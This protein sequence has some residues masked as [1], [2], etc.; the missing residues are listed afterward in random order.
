MGQTA[1]TAGVDEQY[2]DDQQN[3]TP[4]Q[5]QQLQQQQQQSDVEEED[6]NTP[7]G[8]FVQVLYGSKTKNGMSLAYKLAQRYAIKHSPL[9]VNVCSID[10]FEPENM[11]KLEY[12]IFIMSTHENGTAAPNAKL[13][14]DWLQDVSQDFRYGK[15]WLTKLKF[16]V[17]GLGS[18]DYKRNY[19]VIA[20]D[21]KVQMKSLGAKLFARPCILDYS[22]SVDTNTRSNF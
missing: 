1:S 18:S 3:L 6:D 14:M 2:G 13:F 10:Q 5:K 8:P 20:K 22:D 21:V 9:P 19:N 15:G 12:V 11:N 4:E 17:V 16:S 7:T